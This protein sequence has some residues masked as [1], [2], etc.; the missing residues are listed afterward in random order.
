MARPPFLGLKLTW[1]IAPSFLSISILSFH[2]RVPSSFLKTLIYFA[3]VRSK[4][5]CREQCPS[6]EGRAERRQGGDRGMAYK[7]DRVGTEKEDVTASQLQA[8]TRVLLKV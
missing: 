8:P 4:C 6:K 5:F 7:E 3:A 1:L 2:P